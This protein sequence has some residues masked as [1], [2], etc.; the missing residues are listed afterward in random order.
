MLSGAHDSYA[1]TRMWPEVSSH[2]RVEVE[3]VAAAE[4]DVRKGGGRL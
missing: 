2:P 3:V 1:A 4:D